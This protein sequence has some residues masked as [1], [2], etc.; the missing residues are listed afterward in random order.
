MLVTIY[1]PKDPWHDP[2]AQ[3]CEAIEESSFVIIFRDRHVI[4]DWI[5]A[6]A[7]YARATR[8]PTIL[9]EPTTPAAALFVKF[10]LA[11]MHVS[12]IRLLF[13][14]F[15]LYITRQHD[16]IMGAAFLLPF[17]AFAV[18][19]FCCGA[20]WAG[21]AYITGSA[22]AALSITLFGDVLFED[23]WQEYNYLWRTPLRVRQCFY[24]AVP[25]YGDTR[26]F[27]VDG[28]NIGE[29]QAWDENRENI[30]VS[31]IDPVI[32]AGIIV[33]IRFL[34]LDLGLGLAW[35]AIAWLYLVIR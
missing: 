3:V 4:S 8:K 12:A 14:I 17:I 10:V 19:L 15:K 6:E 1:D 5:M 22:V 32:I 26:R 16:I 2:V 29:Q 28:R 23:N 33:W 24:E 25:E 31:G 30:Y 18:G 21:L 35:T 9:A 27:V 34:K 11:W 7:A 20:E 13:P